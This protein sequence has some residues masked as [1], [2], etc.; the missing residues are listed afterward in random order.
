M[1]ELGLPVRGS[2]QGGQAEAAWRRHSS[3]KYGGM[4][5]WQPKATAA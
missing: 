5:A 4:A 1:E 3:S 2:C